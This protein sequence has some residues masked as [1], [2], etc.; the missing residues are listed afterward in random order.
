[1]SASSHLAG[2]IS[3]CEALNPRTLC[4]EA[5]EVPHQIHKDCCCIHGRRVPCKIFEWAEPARDDW[6]VCIQKGRTKNDAHGYTFDHK[7]F[8]RTHSLITR[9]TAHPNTDTFCTEVNSR[10]RSLRSVFVRDSFMARFHFVPGRGHEENTNSFPA[11]DTTV[12]RTWNEERRATLQKQYCIDGP[13][14]SFSSGSVLACFS[15][16]CMSPEIHN[17]I[18]LCAVFLMSRV[19][20]SFS[21]VVVCFLSLFIVRRQ[22]LELVSRELFSVRV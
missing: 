4:K 12:E 5:V 2:R 15:F 7:Y 17:N 1:M 9:R 20:G 3:S 13:L 16:I 18:L 19:L 8:T 6:C 14:L 11:W 10:I 21:G 22:H